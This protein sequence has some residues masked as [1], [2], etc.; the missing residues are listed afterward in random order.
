M[1][2][3][4]RNGGRRFNAIKPNSIWGE[5][6]DPNTAILLLPTWLT[7]TVTETSSVFMVRTVLISSVLLFVCLFLYVPHPL[8]QKSPVG[9]YFLLQ[10]LSVP[11]HTR[12]ITM[13]FGSSWFNL[14]LLFFFFCGSRARH[15]HIYVDSQTSA[16][17]GKDTQ[18]AWRNMKK[19]V[20]RVWAFYCCQFRCQLPEN[21]FI[22]RN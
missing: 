6:K 18:K 11:K 7:V 21:G 13:I 17:D 20:P 12:G 10:I 19:K 1:F 2:Y 16:A 5:K 3:I 4:E 9:L 14:L 15:S 22:L 8:S